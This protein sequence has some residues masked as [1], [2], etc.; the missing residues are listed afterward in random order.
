MTSWKD[1]AFVQSICCLIENTWSITPYLQLCIWLLFSTFLLWVTYLNVALIWFGA[2][3]SVF[4]VQT[5]WTNYVVPTYTF[6]KVLDIS[7]ADKRIN[8]NI[9]LAGTFTILHVKERIS[10]F[11]VFI[12][13]IKVFML[14]SIWA[15]CNLSLDQYLLW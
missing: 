7:L 3:F 13:N 12:S 11:E 9:T 15:W 5:Y 2:I 14:D 6:R 10:D 1:L 8:E 4:F